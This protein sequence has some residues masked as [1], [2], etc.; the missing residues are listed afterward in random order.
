[1]RAVGLLTTLGVAAACLVVAVGGTAAPGPCQPSDVLVQIGGFAYS[2]SSVTVQPG[3]T[4]C[5]TNGDTTSHTVTSDSGAFNSGPLSKDDAFRHTFT[6][7][8]TFAYHCAYPHGMNSQVV[9]GAGV[10]PP[11][12]P[13][14]PPPPLPPPP[15][16]PPAPPPP[17]HQHPL[18]VVG[19]RFSVARRGSARM[20]VGRARI[21][22]PA[23]A[24]LA[25][26]RGRR[27]RASAR[28]Q[29]TAGPNTIRTLLPRSVRRGRWT[30][31]LRVGT[32]RFRRAIRIG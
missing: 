16:P 21:N 29:W 26:L 17:A 5:W 10:T 19:V 24:R 7:E 28:K 9:V 15:P 4:V 27:L 22:H 31:E 6:T 14:P 18:E 11:P 30:A 13:G 20:L 25:L 8:G 3:T 32:Q 1:M 2:P 23:P 12:P